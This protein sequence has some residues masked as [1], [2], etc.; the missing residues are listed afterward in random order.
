M[1][2]RT[3]TV[4]KPTPDTRLGVRLADVKG[5][6][7]G[8]KVTELD[9]S[10]LM[11]GLIG[12]GEIIMSINGIPCTD[13]HVAA[14]TALRADQSLTLV[15]APKKLGVIGRTLTRSSTSKLQVPQ[16][17]AGQPIDLTE[18]PA[19]S[20]RSP[21]ASAPTP[22]T[23]AGGSMKALPLPDP[24]SRSLL[25]DQP[26]QKSAQFTTGAPMAAKD[27]EPAYNNPM[28]NPVASAA[29]MLS[30]GKNLL[31]SATGP[32][33]SKIG[34]VGGSSG[35]ADEYTVTLHRKSS[36]S[37]GMRLVQK[38][39]TDLPYVA[40]IDPNGPAANS[41]IRKFDLILEVNGVDAR[42]SH[43]E[44]KKVR[45]CMSSVRRGLLR[46]S[47]LRPPRAPDRPSLPPHS[48][49]PRARA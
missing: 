12:K 25:K 39:P 4:V 30:S 16:V 47:P 41:S 6:H 37:I 19:S 18:R 17:T 27:A 21:G 38:S 9:P 1:A 33:Y 14:A 45:A 36:K 42:A 34:G 8:V 48:C 32:L 7:G 23:A 35:R 49:V 28:A 5:K 2:T 29:N 13:G 44:L 11:V 3:V 10:S 46:R 20:P 22:S 40:D 43:D 26:I 15:I 31:G 24:S